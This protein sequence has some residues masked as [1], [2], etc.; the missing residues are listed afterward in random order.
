MR[1]LRLNQDDGRGIN[2][3]ADVVDMPVRVV[4]SDPA[5]QPED[6]LTQIAA[7]GDFKVSRPKPGLDL[8]L[9]SR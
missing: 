1:V 2:E 8:D 4:A 5:A 9:G 3:A 6:V 7:D